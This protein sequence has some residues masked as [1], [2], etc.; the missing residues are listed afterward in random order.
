MLGKVCLGLHTWDVSL[1]KFCLGMFNC[2]ILLVKAYLGRFTCEGLLEHT[3]QD[4][5]NVGLN[6]LGLV[7]MAKVYIAY[8]G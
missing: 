1:G 7:L 3:V 8:F 2:E 5:L 6:L 4:W